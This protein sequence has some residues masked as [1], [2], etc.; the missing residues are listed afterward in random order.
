MKNFL[1]RRVTVPN[2]VIAQRVL[3]KMVAA[4]SNFIEDE[5]GEAMVGLVV[6]STQAGGI[7]TIYVLEDDLP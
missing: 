2:L 7:P 3:D 1:S 4:A 6:P 5:T